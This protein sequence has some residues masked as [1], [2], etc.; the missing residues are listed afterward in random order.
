M[1]DILSESVIWA[2]AWTVAATAYLWHSGRS[3][4]SSTPDDVLNVNLMHT[5]VGTLVGLHFLIHYG[6][7][8]ADDPMRAHIPSVVALTHMTTGYILVDLAL[9][10]FGRHWDMFQYALF[11]VLILGAYGL[12]LVHGTGVAGVAVGT[13]G[14]V[15]V[16]GIH[17]TRIFRG[18][19]WDEDRQHAYLIW[20][21]A[22]AGGMVVCKIFGLGWVALSGA[23]DVWVNGPGHSIVVTFQTVICTVGL[24]MNVQICWSWSFVIDEWR[25]QIA[26]WQHQR[27]QKDKTT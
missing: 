9:V 7:E 8:I 22:T 26:V 21:T 3:W 18:W 17:G 25:Y 16:L 15:C 19:G 2:V 1:W 27:A 13:A 11:H 24:L 14:E 23:Q 10:M 12:Y 20:Q 5:V 6:A 4:T